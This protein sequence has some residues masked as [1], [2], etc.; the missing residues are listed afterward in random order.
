M[1]SVE[2]QIKEKIVNLHEDEAVTLLRAHPDLDVNWKDEWGWTAL[3][4]AC[5][6][7]HV[8]VVKLLLVHAAIGVNIQTEYGSTPFLLSCFN[9][10]VSVVQLLLK[11]PRVNINLADHYGCAPLWRASSR[12]YLGVVALLIA[13]GRDL[14][15]LNQKG[16]Y[17]NNEDYTALEVARKNHHTE[18]GSLLERFMANPE[19]TRH[20]VCVKLGLPDAFAAEVFSLIVFIC[21][22]LLQ[23]KTT[24]IANRTAIVN[25]ARFFTI[26]SKLPMEVQM[27]VC[28][29]VG[30]SM[31]HNILRKDSEPA[32]K[33]LARTL[34]F[35][36]DQ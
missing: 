19:L 18:I 28:Y 17:G 11:D 2:Q 1:A 30:G 35:P 15:D 4:R 3:H 10:H 7:G 31:K 12:G 22:D 26:T 33:S 8:K 6:T 32:F 16:S 14:G 25:A 9:N 23:L 29:H 5:R 36:Q 13:S 34:L 20:Q 27:I 21:D 24:S